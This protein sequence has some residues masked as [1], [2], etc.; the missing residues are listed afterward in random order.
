MNLKKP[1][2]E[3][4]PYT[5]NSSGLKLSDDRINFPS[6]KDEIELK[7]ASLFLKLNPQLTQNKST[8]HFELTQSKENDIDF[9]VKS[10]ASNFYLEL[11]ELTPPEISNGGY[12]KLPFEQNS[13]NYFDKIVELIEKKSLKYIGVKEKIILLM[14][15]TDD[16]CNPSTSMEKL[17][18][19]HLHINK[20]KF[21]SIYFFIPI[22][23]I[24]GITIQYYPKAE[25]K[26]LN[27]AE[28]EQYRQ[29]K[30][31]NLQIK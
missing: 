25:V 13:G 9:Y 22:M 4:K 24:D 26:V 1:V 12:S 31:I 30:I 5:L 18:L 14:Y 2:G 23:D 29:V 16:R 7:I 21:D 19:N 10:P 3:L 15:I 11:T 27:Q 8:D 17:L 20:Y 28:I 6:K